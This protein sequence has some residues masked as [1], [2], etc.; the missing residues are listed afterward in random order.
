MHH[1]MI[2]VARFGFGLTFLVLTLLDIKSRRTLF[3]LMKD[4]QVYHPWIMYLGAIFIKGGTSIALICNYYTF[5]AGII[6]IVYI[7]IAC[8]IFCNFWSVPKEQRDFTATLFA[9]YLSICF[10]LL[11]IITHY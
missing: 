5:W 2:D 3:R 1:F 4:K 8:A 9:T 7:L 11:A 6:L 10:G